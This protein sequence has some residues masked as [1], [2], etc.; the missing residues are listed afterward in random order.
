MLLKIHRE[1]RGEH[2][3]KLR[4]DHEQV[5]KTCRKFVLLESF[6][7]YENFKVRQRK[8]RSNLFS[9]IEDLLRSH[10]GLGTNL[11]LRVISKL[12][13]RQ[14]D[15]IGLCLNKRVFNNF[16]FVDTFDLHLKGGSKILWPLKNIWV[17][18]NCRIFGLNH[19]FWS[20]QKMRIIFCSDF[21]ML[22]FLCS[23]CKKKNI[24]I[25]GCRMIAFVWSSN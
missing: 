14:W 12:H 22:L 5:Y 21:I 16:W 8:N 15:L 25:L 24:H 2:V 7:F 20:H 3:H 17:V 18:N 23:F 13:H 11:H 9:G 4:L 1:Y 10:F 6:N 19:Q